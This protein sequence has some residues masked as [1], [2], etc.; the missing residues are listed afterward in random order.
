MQNVAIF[1]KVEHEQED[2]SEIFSQHRKIKWMIFY[3][4]GVLFLPGNAKVENQFEYIIE[5]H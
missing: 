3:F 4:D 1:H 2:T 5:I